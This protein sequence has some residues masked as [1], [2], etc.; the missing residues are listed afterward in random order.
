[1]ILRDTLDW[2]YAHWLTSLLIVVN[3][4]SAVYNLS[5]HLFGRGGHPMNL[6]SATIGIAVA[7]L[8]WHRRNVRFNGRYKIVIQYNT[9]QDP[10][11]A[12]LNGET[13][14]HKMERLENFLKDENIPYTRNLFYEEDT[15]PIWYKRIVG[16]EDFEAVKGM[17]ISLVLKR[18]YIKARL[19]T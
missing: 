3:A 13:F 2:L 19:Y 11:Q 4:L 17:E 12:I 9:D 8:M 14:S 16:Q 5:W 10:I 6:V 15:R 7:W 18:H 1:M